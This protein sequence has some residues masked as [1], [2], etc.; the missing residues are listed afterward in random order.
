MVLS[1]PRTRRRRGGDQRR[2]IGQ[3]DVAKLRRGMQAYFTTLGSQGQ[4]WWGQL[5]KIEPTPTVTNNV[6]LYNALF[7]VPKRY[8]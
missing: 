4:R 7:E 3:A 1:R 5:K 6:V 8:K 2:H